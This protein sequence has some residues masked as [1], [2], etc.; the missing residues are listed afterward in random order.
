MKSAKI[1]SERL[2]ASYQLTRLWEQS[3]NADKDDTVAK[4]IP[5]DPYFDKQWF[6]DNGVDGEMDLN[7][8]R[9]WQD[10]TGAGV[11]IVISDDGFDLDHED[12][13][14]NFNTDIDW[15]Y[16]GDD[17]T[18]EAETGFFPNKHGTA[19]SGIIAAD[20]DNDLGGVGIAHDAELVGFRGFAVTALWSDDLWLDA[21]G[22]GDGIG[23]PNGD[24]TDGDIVS[25]SAGIY[26]SLFSGANFKWSQ[27]IQDSLDAMATISAQG[28]DG[29]GTIIVKANG[30]HRIR[31][32]EDGNTELGDST[33]HSISVAAAEKTGDVANYS[34]PGANL[35]T[36]AFAPDVSATDPDA[37]GIFTTDVTGVNGYITDISEFDGNYVPGFNGTSA[38]TPEVSGIV[39]LMLEA[40]SDLGWRDVQKII[41]MSSRHAGS[42]I[43]ENATGAEEA[44]H[45]DAS[46]FW[47]AAGQ[48]ASNLHWNGGALHFSNDYGFGVIDA[49]AAVRL[50]ETWE[51]TGTTA[52]EISETRDAD[53]A[54]LEPIV[55][56]ENFVEHTATFD[57]N[58]IVQH[59]SVNVDFAVDE[60]ED[61]EIFLVS[62]NGTEVQLINDTFSADASFNTD[63]EADRNG[64]DF[65][66]TAFLGEQGNGDWTVKIRDDDGSESGTFKTFDVDVTLYGDA[67][68]DD[69]LFVYTDGFSD[70]AGDSNHLTKLAGGDGVTTLNAAA[71]TSDIVLDLENGRGRIDDVNI[72]TSNI[73]K[74]FTGDGDDYVT[75]SSKVAEI[76]SGRGDDF[77]IGGNGQQTINGGQDDDQLEGRNGADRLSGDDG[78]DLLKG[79]NGNDYLD[80]GEGFDFVDG[81]RGW[82]IIEFSGDLLDYTIS[83]AENI[84]TFI[85]NREDSPDG[86][87]MVTSV[88]HAQFSDTRLAFS[89]LPDVGVITTADMFEFA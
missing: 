33:R 60:V 40:N 34:T 72:T 75:G 80:G 86:T 41:A 65:G 10:Y 31:D 25:L 26:S 61:M 18:P 27:D 87:D 21:A 62:P 3:T 89:D 8:S 5:T 9:V 64:W 35:L 7:V 23:N 77:V 71:V 13:E 70:Y 54:Q 14:S 63:A 51:L 44:N 4:V 59:V 24:T 39:A 6:L 43:G 47:N 88:E 20:N 50:A 82:D 2:N 32:N 67:A 76:S 22:L 68:T 69:E 16:A 1:G 15:D 56:N 84:F 29:L 12:L 53:E 36:T 49:L 28:R 57:N 73:E 17:N 19:V 58:I 42:E 45:G 74:A 52:T 81:G 46:W 48:S 38:A 83:M 78:T 85:D 37:E 30:N 11:R 79:G 55:Y 66:S